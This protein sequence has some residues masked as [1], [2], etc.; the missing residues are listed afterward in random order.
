MKISI[1]IPIG[2]KAQWKECE[3]SIR[4]AIIHASKDVEVEMLPCWDLEHKGA[5][6]AR[7]EGLA[8]A[9]GEW[10]AWIDCDDV[11]E[12]CWL[13]EIEGAIT[14]HPEV[15]IV[16]FEAT[17]V[18]RG[19]TRPLV[20][21]YQGMVD[22]DAFARELLRDDGMPAWMWTRVFRRSLFADLAFDGRVKQDYR[23]FLQILPRI[24][25]VWSVGKPLYRYVRHGHGLSNYVQEMDY[26][27]AG[28]DF[29]EL[30]AALPMVWHKDAKMGLGL[31][32][33]DVVR[34]S[35]HENGARHFVRKY[36][37]LIVRDKTL[38]IRLKFKALLA[39]L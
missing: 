16:Q 34:H 20:Y 15:D 1:I 36:V 22:G 29:E 28:A 19:R 7:N 25:K 26:A 8:K 13:S 10:I 38:P 21:R 24:K 17:E 23:M 32:M 12:K 11:V 14:D 37:G 6:L 18:R 2:D 9:T 4:A 5:Y 30:I 31:V 33:A 3:K 27:K 39:C 35:H